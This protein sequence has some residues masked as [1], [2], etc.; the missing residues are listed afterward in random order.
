VFD[1]FFSNKFIFFI[2]CIL[3]FYFFFLIN[4]RASLQAQL[5]SQLNG[6]MA[7]RNTLD[8]CLER[9][10][11]G[12]KP[13]KQWIRIR[14]LLAPTRPSDRCLVFKSFKFPVLRTFFKKLKKSFRSQ[15]FKAKERHA[16]GAL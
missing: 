5:R 2:F 11:V 6:A 10:K 3:F 13:G 1:E 16:N 15:C 12:G 4:N 9:L 8:K 7:A 14:K